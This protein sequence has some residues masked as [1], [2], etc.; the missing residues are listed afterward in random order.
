M[1]TQWALAEPCVGGVLL[2]LKQSCSHKTDSDIMVCVLAM[3][4]S[5]DVSSEAQVT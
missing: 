2:S 4:N 1:L 5:G 3:K